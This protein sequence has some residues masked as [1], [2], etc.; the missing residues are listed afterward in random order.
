MGRGLLGILGQSLVSLSRLDTLRSVWHRVTKK[1]LHP[2]Q[3]VK[4]MED[5]TLVRI[6]WSEWFPGANNYVVQAVDNQ[7]EELLAEVTV[8]KDV[9]WSLPGDE[10]DEDD[11]D[12]GLLERLLDAYS[13]AQGD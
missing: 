2:T 10:F 1:L 12:E 3:K 9:F 11:L 5:Y 13:E 6:D 8:S 4:D 7:T